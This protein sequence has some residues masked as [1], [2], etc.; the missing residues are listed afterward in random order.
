MG[1]R[2][3]NVTH[4]VTLEAELYMSFC[5]GHVARWAFVRQNVSHCVRKSVRAQLAPESRCHQNYNYSHFKLLKLWRLITV[6]DGHIST[7]SVSPRRR[8]ES[9]RSVRIS[10]DMTRYR[11]SSV[12]QP[13]TIRLRLLQWFIRIRSERITPF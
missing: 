2:L 7:M 10:T 3:T 13:L 11:T 9:F 12:R 4:R 6:K 1:V 5:S 8:S